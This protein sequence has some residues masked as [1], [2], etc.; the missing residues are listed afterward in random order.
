MKFYLVFQRVIIFVH[1][2]FM[3]ICI[4]V[5][6]YSITTLNPIINIIL[7]NWSTTNVWTKDLRVY[8]VH[9]SSQADTYLASQSGR[10]C[11]KFGTGVVLACARRSLQIS[12]ENS[13]KL[14]A[15][16]ENLLGM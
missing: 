7:T 10:S 14:Y 11:L 1:N 5:Y 6:I 9:H 8:F 13:K 15:L 12:N 3:Y 2:M 4:C 16:W